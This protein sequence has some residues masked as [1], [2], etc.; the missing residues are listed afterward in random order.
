[1]K[2]DIG[3]GSHYGDIKDLATSEDYKLVKTT[4]GLKKFLES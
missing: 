1:L 4:Q 3:V 2:S